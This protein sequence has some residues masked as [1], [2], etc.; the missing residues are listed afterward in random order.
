MLSKPE[1]YGTEETTE[2]V[3]RVFEGKWNMKVPIFV[4]YLEDEITFCL[5]WHINKI[6]HTKSN[7]IQV[8]KIVI[9]TRNDPIG[10]LFICVPL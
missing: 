10:L 9:R 2:S 4:E 7:L 8:G 3:I 6:K 1:L 5:F